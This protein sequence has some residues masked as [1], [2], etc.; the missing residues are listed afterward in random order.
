MKQAVGP[1]LPKIESPGLASL[2]KTL[3]EQHFLSLELLGFTLFLTL[4]GSGVIA[5][6]ERKE[7]LINEQ[8]PEGGI[9]S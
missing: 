1:E 8:D 9:S 3:V 5:R 4:V 7:R 2:G 6:A